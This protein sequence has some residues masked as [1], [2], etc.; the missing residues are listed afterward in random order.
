M[1]QTS[2]RGLAMTRAQNPKN[3][4]S[5]FPDD[6]A[7]P[8]KQNVARTKGGGHELLGG[9][10]IPP[11]P[12]TQ[13]HSYTW[14]SFAYT[15]RMD[16]CS[17]DPVGACSASLEITHMTHLSCIPAA[18][19]HCS[20]LTFGACDAVWHDPASTSQGTVGPA[21]RVCDHR[22]RS[23]ALYALSPVVSSLCISWN[24]SPKAES[25]TRSPRSIVSSWP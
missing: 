12:Q 8:K 17:S 3:S 25:S 18:R 7:G 13:Q 15:D 22:V 5:L 1:L 23:S 4:H 6:T 2:S 19:A 9:P 11:G 14:P 10:S 24:A 16:S 21:A 20:S